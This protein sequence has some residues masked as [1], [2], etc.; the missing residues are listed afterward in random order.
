MKAMMIHHYGDPDQFALEEVPRPKL[1]RGHVLVRVHGSTVNPL[2]ALIRR[3]MARSFVWLKFPAVLGVDLSG[4]VVELGPGVEGFELGDR[5]YAFTGAGAGGGYGEFASVP[6]AYLARVPDNLDLVKAGAI[7]GVG[8]TAYEAFTVHAPLK[9]GMRVFINGAS[10]GVGTH[11]I[12]I[13]RAMGA[14][15]TGTC[16]PPKAELVARLGAEVIDYTT[17]EPFPGKGTYD[18]VLNAVRDV[19]EGPLRDLLKRGGTL[20][21]IVGGPLDIAAAKISNLVRST[22]TVPFLVSP[23][24]TALEGLSILIER[25]EV[26]PVVEKVY[27]LTDLA[28][29]HRRVETGRVAGKVCIDLTTVHASA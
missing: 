27:P 6:Q 14:H 10:G 22:R 23:K 20:V 5:V 25:G 4:E 12:Q 29:A 1:E 17:G 16:S 11:A 28:A 18:V 8:A 19:D 13:A 9:P 26:E 21:S 7:A 2:D 15:V 3:G 24:A